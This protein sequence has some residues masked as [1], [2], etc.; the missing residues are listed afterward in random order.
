[1]TTRSLNALFVFFCVLAASVR[2]GKGRERRSE[3]VN[4][5]M[6]KGSLGVYES[7]RCLRMHANPAHFH[8]CATL[9]LLLFFH[10]A[11]ACA[12]TMTRKATFY[13]LENRNDLDDDTVQLSVD[14]ICDNQVG[15]CL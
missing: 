5:T 6:V 14:L 8:A 2:A 4:E 3:A 13:G 7:F 11:A 12:T 15:S 9:L 10:A 1:M